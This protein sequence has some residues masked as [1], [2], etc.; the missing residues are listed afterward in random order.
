MRN[1]G[2]GATL[3]GALLLS[4]CGAPDEILPGERLPLRAGTFSNAVPVAGPRGLALPPATA[5]ADWTHRNGGPAHVGGH[6]ALPAT[7]ALAF[8]VPVGEGDTR[9]SR[10]TAEPV[11]AG[12]RIFTLDARSV[13]SAFSTSGALLW[14]RDV[15]P[16]SDE[17]ADAS[18]GG[19]ATDGATIY[20]STGY[21]RLSAIDASTGAVRWTQDLDAPGSSAPTVLGDLVL[22]VARD[23]RAWALETSTGRIRW[24]VQGLPSTATW[25]GGAGVAARGDIVVLPHPSGEV[26]GVFPEGGLV[27]WTSL[28]SGTRPGSA[29]GYAATEIG[30]DPVLAGSTVYVGNYSGR[31]AALD[32]ATGETFWSIPE[33]AQSP[34]WPA[35]DS[36]FLVNDLG[37]LLRVEASTGGVIWRVPLPRA[38]HRRGVTAFFGPV[39][40]GGRLIVASTDGALRQFD[41]TT[42]SA[43]GDVAL[44][45]GAASA[46]VVAGSTLYI[47]TEDGRLNAFR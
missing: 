24:Q 46:P 38:E 16:P 15:R 22:M 27:R 21:G 47:V 12:G 29:A 40:A 2:L 3:L 28:V 34:V 13:V 7:L 6:P 30:G 4:A 20:A 5:N 17:R 9:R 35:G 39:L 32:T 14:T 36:V 42:G 19:L 10:I 8:S 41:P 18:G 33:G 43:L 45:S 1:K 25:A 37:E 26:R 31:L 23:S 11:V 44:P